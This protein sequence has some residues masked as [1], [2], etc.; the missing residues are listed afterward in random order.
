MTLEA[1]ESCMTGVPL[2]MSNREQLRVRRT[3][4]SKER[5]L[6]LPRRHPSIDEC[7]CERCIVELLLTEPRHLSVVTC[8]ITTTLTQQKLHAIFKM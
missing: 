7:H 2:V 1:S 6:D 4:S 3:M 8:D 5:R